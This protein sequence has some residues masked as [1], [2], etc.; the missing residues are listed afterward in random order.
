VKVIKPPPQAEALRDGVLLF[1]S[2]FFRLF[3]RLSSE[4]DGGGGLSCRPFRPHLLVISLYC[5]SAAD[6]VSKQ[7][8]WQ[9]Q[10]SQIGRTMV[11]VIEYVAQS[12]EVTQ[13]HLKCDPWVGR[14][15]VPVSIPL[16]LCL[17]LL[18]SLRYSTSNNGETLNSGLSHSRSLDV[19]KVDRSFVIFT[20]GPCLGPLAGGRW[21]PAPSFYT[22]VYRVIRCTDSSGCSV[23]CAQV[24]VAILYDFLSVLRCKNAYSSIKKKK[25][26]R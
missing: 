23:R 15:Q 13:G 21:S 26:K 2:S 10:L 8:F 1:V 6:S 16:W 25:D 17:Y 18:P 7:I 9:A 20:K 24:Y 19:A 14:V 4:T 22:G 12:L 5:K 3:V 11:C